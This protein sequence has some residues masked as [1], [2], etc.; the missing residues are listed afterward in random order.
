MKDKGTLFFVTV[1]AICLVIVSFMIMG[2]SFKLAKIADKENII[3]KNIE[4]FVEFDGGKTIELDGYI[5][6]NKDRKNIT[7]KN[8]G[9]T[10]V[11]FDIVWKSID[12]VNDT[13]VDVFEYS[14][15]GKSLNELSTPTEI[16]DIV[17]ADTN[18][19]I[20][21]GEKIAAGDE[22][23]YTLD[24][25]YTGTNKNSDIN[26]YAQIGANVRH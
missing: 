2:D 13:G 26:L 18:K 17:P 14:L 20:V 23:T 3:Y 15:S 4:T 19:T 21:S 9:D 7:I 1:I 6:K 5:L 24:V 11:Y 22:V 16:M 8:T 10:D 12:L 25:T